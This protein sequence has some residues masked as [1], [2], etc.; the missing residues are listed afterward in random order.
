MYS[1]PPALKSTCCLPSSMNVSAGALQAADLRIP[2]PLAGRRVPRL[3]VLAVAQEQHAAG[4]RE[5]PELPPL[6]SLRHVILPV[7]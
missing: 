7:L 3:D 2:E 1:P 5:Q 6:S 4:R